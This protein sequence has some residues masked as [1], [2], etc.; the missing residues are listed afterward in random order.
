[1][2]RRMSS[3]LRSA[4]SGQGVANRGNVKN[5]AE[6]PTKVTAAPSR[7]DNR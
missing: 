6:W 3:H 7:A 2:S 1:M 4:T 5:G